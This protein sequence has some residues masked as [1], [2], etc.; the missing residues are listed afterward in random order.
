MTYVLTKDLT[1]AYVKPL[2]DRVNFTDVTA[3]YPD[4]GTY[5]IQD[6]DGGLRCY[7]NLDGVRIDMINTYLL[8]Q[9]G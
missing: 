4:Y 6:L 8:Q 1:Y 7:N 3:Q 5:V 9:N 2:I